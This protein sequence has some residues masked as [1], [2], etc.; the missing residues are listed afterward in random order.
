MKVGKR[1]L[2]I[3]NLFLSTTIIYCTAI[4]GKVLKGRFLFEDGLFDFKYILLLL[5]VVI[6]FILYILIANGRYKK[7]V[8]EVISF[9]YFIILVLYVPIYIALVF[10]GSLTDPG[11][12]IITF[13][14]MSVVLIGISHFTVNNHQHQSRV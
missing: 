2:I 12:V 11:K 9:S 6:P 14:V 5:A 10:E 13:L 1:I 3:I 8:V 7:N 4:V